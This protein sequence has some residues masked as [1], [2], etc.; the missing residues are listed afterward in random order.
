MIE[1]SEP[2][3]LIL[4]MIS[5]NNDDSYDELILQFD[6]IKKCQETKDYLDFKRKE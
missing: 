4:A 5:L 2:R 3:N 1:K 6:N